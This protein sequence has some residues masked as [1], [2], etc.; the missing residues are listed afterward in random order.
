MAN[1]WGTS[2]KDSDMVIGV[3]PNYFSSAQ[4]FERSIEITLTDAC[5]DCGKAPGNVYLSAAAF[6]ALTGDSL[7]T[8]VVDVTWSLSGSEGSSR[9]SKPKP[10]R[11]PYFVSKSTLIYRG[12]LEDRM[13]QGPSVNLVY[14]LPLSTT[15]DMEL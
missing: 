5:T 7:A 11:K 9:I 6:Q 10:T 1:A 13:Q 8:G 4:C 2:S 3:G 12:T 15:A 14:R